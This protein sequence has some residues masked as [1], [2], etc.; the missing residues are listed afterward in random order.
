MNANSAQCHCVNFIQWRHFL[1][2]LLPGIRVY[3]FL[4]LLVLW[5]VCSICPTN[6]WK[7]HTPHKN[8]LC[9]LKIIHILSSLSMANFILW[10]AT[11]TNHDIKYT[12]GF[13]TSMLASI[14]TFCR[15]Q[16]VLKSSLFHPRDLPTPV[17]VSDKTVLNWKMLCLCPFVMQLHPCDT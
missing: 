9:M 6:F 5:F 3:F 14:Q 13:S 4:A 10:Q 8:F 2:Y 1:S 15:S 11:V 16:D 7:T 12:W 17:S